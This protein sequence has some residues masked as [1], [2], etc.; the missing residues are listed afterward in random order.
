[1]YALKKMYVSGILYALFS[2][3]INYLTIIDFKFK[4]PL[5]MYIVK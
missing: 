4:I 1:M 3:L 5:Y 2:E